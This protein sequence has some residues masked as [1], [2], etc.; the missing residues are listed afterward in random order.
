MLSFSTV[1]MADT[2]GTVTLQLKSLQKSEILAAH[3]T[4]LNQPDSDERNL[5]LALTQLLNAIVNDDDGPTSTFIEIL[6]EYGLEM[7]STISTLNHKMSG[8]TDLFYTSTKSLEDMCTFLGTWKNNIPSSIALLDTIPDSFEY[9]MTMPDTTPIQLDYTDVLLL[10]S[11]MQ[12]LYGFIEIF[13]AHK[14]D[15]SFSQLG[16]SATFSDY[17][18]KNS[19]FR[20]RSDGADYLNS[21]KSWFIDSAQTARAML[22]AAGNEGPTPVGVSEL[23]LVKSSE[24]SSALIKVD[25]IIG[26]LTSRSPLQLSGGPFGDF[27][28]NALFDGNISFGEFFPLID[29]QGIVFSTIGHEINDDPT[30]KNMFPL[31]THTDWNI[32]LVRYLRLF[33]Y[34][35]KWNEGVAIANKAD[36]SEGSNNGQL[37]MNLNWNYSNCT[38]LAIPEYVSVDRIDPSNST[39]SYF[40][41]SVLGTTNYSFISPYQAIKS[42]SLILLQEIPQGKLQH[43]LFKNGN[44][45]ISTDAEGPLYIQIT[46]SP[47]NGL[48]LSKNIALG[49]SIGRQSVLL[50]QSGTSTTPAVNL[51]NIINMLL[52]N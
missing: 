14:M 42:D 17:V 34:R 51:R 7:D 32:Q 39:W 27:D 23:F 48:Y 44:I 50:T 20:Y 30:L 31:A 33:P 15:T 43:V 11:S 28:L 25:M 10:K 9:T 24:L 36:L 2:Y 8:N 6:D 29:K 35:M 40:G 47:Y 37:E 49:K 12:F 18:S 3:N 4:V 38:Y 5:F 1:A 13:C 21:A 46:S 19:L 41:S 45:S 52:L 26:N 22:V 16:N